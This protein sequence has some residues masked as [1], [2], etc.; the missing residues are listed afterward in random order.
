MR[1]VRYRSD[2]EKLANKLAMRERG[3]CPE[4]RASKAAYA[5]ARKGRRK[6]WLNKYKEAKGC[7][8]CDFKGPA[9][10]F[11]WHHVGVGKDF[12]I[13]SSLLI[14]LKRMFN[15]MRKC[16]LV[17]SNCHRKIHGGYCGS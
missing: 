14:S 10:C 13:N 2:K 6:Y 11:D 9:C 7:S 8:M 17:C 3:K 16:I 4:Y 12:E 15:E 5:K 1:L